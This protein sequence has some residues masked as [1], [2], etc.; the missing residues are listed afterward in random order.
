M[1]EERYIW[2]NHRIDTVSRTTVSYEGRTEF[3]LLGVHACLL[4]TCTASTK[5]IHL[6]SISS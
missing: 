1:F 5:M 4:L 2:I 3:S 6:F